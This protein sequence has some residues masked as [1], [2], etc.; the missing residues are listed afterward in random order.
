MLTSNL[1]LSAKY[2]YYGTGFSLEPAGGLDGQAS[3]ARPE[4][5]LRYDARTAIPAAAAHLQRR[6]QR[7]QDAWAARTTSSSASA[8]VGPSF[9][10]ALWPG[11]KIQGASR[12]A[13][14]HAARLY[15][16]GAGTDLDEYFN[17]Y[18]GDT[19]S[20]DRLTRR[21][22]RALRPPVGR[23]R[24]RATP[25]QRRFPGA[26]ARGSASR[27]Y[28]APFTW[29]DVTPRV[30]ITYALDEARKTCCA[31]ASAATPASSS[32]GIVGFMN[33]SS[34]VGFDRL[35][36]G[37]SQRRPVRASPNEINTSV[38]G[39]TPLGGFNPAAPDLGTVRKPARPRFESAPFEST[40]DRLG[41]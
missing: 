34:Q 3:S 7:L 23:R 26:R 5:D 29:N 22:R 6:R 20:R 31:P 15:R 13:T 12:I 25:Q 19:F 10:A 37:R 28:K 33:P 4:H 36:V 16:E 14:D 40:D 27:G 8:S 18:V 21:P 24:C 41:S 17:F 11:D 1:F 30:G 38:P 2:A 35:S 9:R 39:S 32:N